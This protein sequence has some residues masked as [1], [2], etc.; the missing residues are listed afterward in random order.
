MTIFGVGQEPAIL[1]GYGPIDPATAAQ[2]TADATSWRRILTDPMTG[3][4][5]KTDPRDYRPTQAMRDHARLVHPECVFTGCTTPSEHADI[6]HN[7]DFAQGGDTVQENL[8]PECPQ[9][10]RTK[11]CVGWI[12]TQNDADTLTLSSPA[13]IVYTREPAGKMS[14]ASKAL[15]DTAATNTNLDKANGDPNNASKTTKE[16]TV[17]TDTSDCPF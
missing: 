17:S 7:H 13:G 4:I 11:H 5:L 9:H 12:V 3:R 2:L 14:R 1:R 10:H 15:F 16:V 8:A 6:D